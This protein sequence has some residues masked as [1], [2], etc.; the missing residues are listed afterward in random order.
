MQLIH[1]KLSESG[2]TAEPAELT[3]SY[4]PLAAGD[5]T[6]LL[7]KQSQYNHIAELM[8]LETIELEEGQAVA[9]DFG[10]SRN[11]EGMLNQ[12]LQL[13]TGAVVEAD[14]AILSPVVSVVS[15]YLIVP[16]ALLSS[17]GNP[18]KADHYYTWH[19]PAG[20]RELRLPGD[21]C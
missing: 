3:L 4:Y 5:E 14:R 15:S 20:Q 10:L 7:V 11:G 16:D 2:I 21:N 19:G 8:E 9:V 12:P 18:T 17:L 13:Q 6:L 1:Q